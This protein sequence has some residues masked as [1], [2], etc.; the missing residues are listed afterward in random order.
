VTKVNQRHV[1]SKQSSAPAKQTDAATDDAPTKSTSWVQSALPT[2]AKPK[3]GNFLP[4]DNKAQ[5]K[6]TMDAVK[7]LAPMG[8]TGV[9]PLQALDGIKDGK[10]TISIPL[11]SGH[12]SVGP[13]VGF[14]VKPGTVAQVTVDV[15]DGRIMPAVDAQGRPT[16]RGTQVKV[17]P[18]LDLP[19]WLTGKG[20]YVKDKNGAQAALKADIGGFFDMKVKDL[21]ST[22]LSDIVKGFSADDPNK[23]KSGMTLPA[24]MLRTDQVRFDAHVSMKD[25]VVNA[26]AAKL[27]LAPGTQLN[28]SGTGTHATLDGQ[29]NMNGGTLNHEGTKVALGPG[30][31]H[32]HADYSGD[33]KGTMKVAA[34]I[35]NLNAQIDNLSVSHPKNR[36]DTDPDHVEIA[37]TSIKNGA[38]NLNATF[39]P[40]AKGQKLPQMTSSQV[41]IKGDAE[42][43][44]VGAKLTVKDSVGNSTVN[45]GAGHFKGSIDMSPGANKL[46]IDVQNVTADVK[47]LHGQN[48]GASIG[49]SHGHVEGDLSLNADESKKQLD[50]T[51][52]ARNMDFKIDGYKGQGD[53]DVVD[54]KSVEFGG[55]GT[56]SLGTSKGLNVD[57]NLSVRAEVNELNV[58]DRSGRGNVEMTK[59]TVLEGSATHFHVNEK[60]ELEINAKTKIDANL[61]NMDVEM[62]SMSARA[63]GH[64]SGSADIDIGR[65]QASLVFHDAQTDLTID[66]AKV[67]KTTGSM[68]LDLAKGSRIKLNIAEARYGATANGPTNERL[69]LNPGSVIDA[70]LDGGHITVQGQRIQLD[71]GSHARLEVSD[72]S[73]AT[74]ADPVLKGSLTIDAAA[75]ADTL[76][77]LKLAGVKVNEMAPA[78]GRVQLTMPDVNL[79][80][81]GHATF[82]NTK[83]SLDA[84]VGNFRPALQAPGAAVATEDPTPKGVETPEQVKAEL[85][86]AEAAQKAAPAFNPMD[87]AKRLQ[88]GTLSLELPLEGTVSKNWLEKARFDPGTKMKIDFAVKDG[89]VVPSDTKVAFSQPGHV[90][91]FIKAEGANLD[92]NGRLHVGFGVGPFSFDP[93]V[94]FMKPLPLEVGALMDHLGTLSGGAGSLNDE[95]KKAVK[96]DQT[97]INIAEAQFKP[98]P[99]NVP[100]GT[101][102]LGPDT[103]FSLSGSLHDATLKGKVDLNAVNIAKDGLALKGRKGG[104]ELTVSMKDGVATT[105]LDHLN[106]DTEYA[107]EKRANG[108]YINL[109]EGRVNDGRLSVSVPVGLPADLGQGPKIGKPTIANFDVP[110]FSGTVK[111]ARITQVD[112][113]GRATTAEI[114]H[115]NVDGE[116]HISPNDIRV[117]GAITQAD[118]AVKNLRAKG[119]DGD[120]DVQ[121]ARL[122]G[123][124]TLD[125]SSAKG[126]TIDAVANSMDVKATGAHLNRDKTTTAGPTRITGS[127]HVVFS[128]NDGLSLEGALHVDSS[129]SGTAEMPKP[130]QIDALTR[131]ALQNARTRLGAPAPVPA[132]RPAANAPASA[133]RP[134]VADPNAQRFIRRVTVLRAPFQASGT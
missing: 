52:K 130:D 96:L 64:L 11:G 38:L 133:T 19:L 95:T 98:G 21:N 48:Q 59:G 13:L 3:T 16:G 129:I 61:K 10:A 110:R 57:G 82:N 75:H 66:D 86:A 79:T 46:N 42:G 40:A 27:N 67:G 45:L 90:L 132:T 23:K 88:N 84:K 85:A 63:A 33:P 74:G 41:R 18:P 113:D 106:I 26:G 122:V 107:V 81:D 126:L 100:G 17:N 118:M 34:S 62:G 77:G 29:I 105:T 5:A 47:D 94:P 1:P 35:S 28:V 54:F 117:H 131:R 39:K 112:D 51:A 78:S 115:A 109:A 114:G 2:V 104:A 4:I 32:L 101:I 60:R 12:Y 14:N 31:A 116:V 68:D 56:M 111:G 53:G 7:G 9:D 30:S 121:S 43:S 36:N 127:G 37:Q 49:I 50:F 70:S 123:A 134:A 6:A 25:N 108:D 128:S 102:D 76:K 87:A 24:G 58:N 15:K 97:K 55:S 83:I 65:G 120:V 20:A 124:A 91:H 44:M 103:K 125:M 89:K 73:A 93:K 119:P 72:L 99:M 8:V 92:E 80:S 71:K 22:K 69:K